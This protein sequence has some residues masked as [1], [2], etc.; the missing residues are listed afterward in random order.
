MT[1]DLVQSETGDMIEVDLRR[2]DI[3]GHIEE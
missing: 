1:I 2:R 3:D